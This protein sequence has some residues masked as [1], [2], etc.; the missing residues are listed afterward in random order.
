MNNLDVLYW[1]PYKGNVGTINATIFSAQ[2]LRKK[3]L[4]VALV[5]IHD[6][7]EGRELG[8]LQVI[9]LGLK[10]YLPILPSKGWGFR[11]SMMIYCIYS[12][13]LLLILFNRVKPKVV[14]S[15]LLGFLPLGVRFFSKHRPIIINSVQGMPRFNILRRVIWS[16]LY[17]Y[18]D[19]VLTLS[20]ETQQRLAEQ[21]PGLKNKISYIENPIISENMRT[22]TVQIPEESEFILGMGRLSRQKDFTTLIN[23]YAIMSKKIV[24]PKLVILGEGEERSVL[25]ELVRS[26][27]L[28]NKV[29]LKG[30]VSNPFGYLSKAKLFVLSSCW[31]DMGHA[32]VE[33]AYFN[34]PIVSTRCP[35]GQEEFLNYGQGGLLCAVGDYQKMAELMEEALVNSEESRERALFAYQKSLNYTQDAHGNSLFELIRGHL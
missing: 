12:F 16:K 25:Q 11:L 13:P 29:I 26:L 27:N 5:K 15:S 1:T 10:R 23:A 35:S 17:K 28:E 9:D 8:D 6:E 18:S 3:G 19:R 20:K 4:R 7:W 31:E 33:A 2:A 30:F 21:F 24:G 32:L 14:I 22:A 34:V